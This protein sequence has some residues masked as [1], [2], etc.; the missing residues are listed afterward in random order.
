MRSGQQ[1]KRSRGRGGNNFNRKG[2]NPLTRTYDSSGPDVKVRGTAQHV[3]EKYMS[4]ARDAQGAGD[5]VMAENYLQHAEHYNR[6]I[7]AAQSQL[8]ERHQRDDR[9]DDDNDEAAAKKGNNN[10]NQSSSEERSERKEQQRKQEQQVDADGPQPVIDGT[11]AEVAAEEADG[12]PAPKSRR[13]SPAASRPRRTKRAAAENTGEEGNTAA[14]SGSENS[15]E[16]EDAAPKKPVRRKRT[17]KAEA[18]PSEEQ[19][20]PAMAEVDSE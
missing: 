11:P 6:I 3:A 5:R 8:Q 16:S 10:S 17:P 13:R 18:K 20:K 14:A 12:Q 9:S 7:A 2:A 1:N 4:L 15:G 19:G